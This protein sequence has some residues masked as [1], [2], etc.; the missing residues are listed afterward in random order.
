MAA[1]LKPGDNT[2]TTMFGP[3]R[4]P[5]TGGDKE[6]FVFFCFFWKV[7]AVLI[8]SGWLQRPAHFSGPDGRRPCLARGPG[9]PRS[10]TRPDA[11]GSMQSHRSPFL[12]TP[13]LIVFA[14]GIEREKHHRSS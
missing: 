14:Q 2:G 8:F 1:I 4:S 13:A 5:R 6:G 9:G 7:A 3:G 12:L 10:A 11:G